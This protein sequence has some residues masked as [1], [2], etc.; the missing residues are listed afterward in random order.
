MSSEDPF[1][2]LELSRDTATVSDVKRSYARR[3]KT[4]R[5]DDDPQGFMALRSAMDAALAHIKWRDRYGTP[6][7]SSEATSDEAASKTSSSE[8]PPPSTDE[9]QLSDAGQPK[10]V[11]TPV[12]APDVI[13]TLQT[14]PAPTPTGADWEEP[15]DLWDDDE[16]DETDIEERAPDAAPSQFADADAATQAIFDIQSLIKDSSARRDWANWLTILERPAFDGVDA[17]QILSGRLR[18][19]IGDHSGMNSEDAKPEIPED[20]PADILIRLDDRFGWSHQTGSDWFERNY[21]TW[22]GRLIEKAEQRTGVKSDGSKLRK[23]WGDGS[24]SEAEGGA[25][26][27]WLSIAWMVV[28][29]GL[30][31]GVI[32]IITEIVSG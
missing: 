12:I 20:I 31:I 5:P 26:S 32:R 3:L 30:I 4:T 22:I 10:P 25:T 15:E 6:N 8:S 13:K 21:N 16:D 24:V 29:I 27:A 9:D 1:T 23:H 2:L 14:E 19:F 18:S 17:F 28:R 11:P 7:T